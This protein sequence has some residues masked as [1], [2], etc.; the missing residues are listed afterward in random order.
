MR[1]QWLWMALATLWCSQILFIKINAI[2]INTIKIFNPVT[3]ATGKVLQQ[4]EQQ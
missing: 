3:D 1:R 2:K 4:G